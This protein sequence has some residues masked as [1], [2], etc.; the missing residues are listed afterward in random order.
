MGVFSLM[1]LAFAR[2][3]LV[4]SVLLLLGACSTSDETFKVGVLHSLSGTMADSEK[5]VAMAT[6]MAIEEINASGGLLGKQIEPMLFDGQS[7]DLHFL[8]LAKKLLLEDDV[9]TVFGCWTSSCRKTLKPLF[10]QNDGLLVYPVQFEGIESSK[11]ILYTGATAS[12]QVMPA[13]A[14]GLLN[15]GSRVMLVG[16]DYVFPR[17]ANSIAKHQAGMLGGE[18][19][20]ELYYIL[21]DDVLR[22]LRQRVSDAKPDFILSTLNGSSNGEFFRILESLDDPIPVISTSISEEELD[23]GSL[24]LPVYVANSY[25][26]QL[27]RVENR[28][29]VARFREYVGDDV[30]VS[31]AVE[32]AYTGVFLWAH[33]VQQAHSFHTG[34]IISALPSL[35]IQG[36][37]DKLVVALESHHVWRKFYL[38]KLDGVNGFNVIYTEL[39]FLPPNPYPVF[40]S[41]RKWESFLNDLYT[42]W[43]D[44]WHAPLLVTGE[45]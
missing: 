40:L 33:A 2:S 1:H 30:T 21:G 25:F 39:D 9:N 18:I 16:S 42:L 37:S 20:D 29:F 17:V 19:V 13:L 43:G 38:A 3:V 36:P 32:A 15:I 5:P 8:R 4:A 23:L 26:E 6:L 11:N 14:W 41:V 31:A 44:Q 12:Q 24:T 27:S 45:G 10:E 7:N 35:S 28:D 34:D 22:N